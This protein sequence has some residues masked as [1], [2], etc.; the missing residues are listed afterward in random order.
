MLIPNVFELIDAWRADAPGRPA[1][2]AVLHVGAHEC[3]E[4]GL[5]NSRGLQAHWVEAQ[6]RLVQLMRDRGVHVIQAAVAET[7]GTY[8]PFYVTNNSQSSSMLPL[9]TH[10]Q[11]HPHVHVTTT[12][13]VQ[14]R[15]LDEIMDTEHIGADVNFANLDIQG[16]ELEALKSLGDKIAQFDFI[17]SEVNERELYAGCALLPEMDAWLASKGFERNVM[18]MTQHGWGDALYVRVRAA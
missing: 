16:V 18:N 3:E 14:T 8:V 12:I 6:P 17:Y 15:R 2:R 4:L 13:V 1:P 7:A 10:A 9:K 5:Y 11:E